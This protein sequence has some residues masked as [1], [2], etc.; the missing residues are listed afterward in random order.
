MSRPPAEP[1]D[2]LPELPGRPDALAPLPEDREE[3]GILPDLPARSAAPEALDLAFEPADDELVPLPARSTPIPSAWS[4]DPVLVPW[5][6][7]ATV[8]EPPER[9]PALL[10]PTRP[11]SARR[12]PPGPPRRAHVSLAGESF[13]VDLHPEP[14]AAEE[15]V[16]GRDALAG[17]FAVTSD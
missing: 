8:G 1:E 16:L 15:L 11:T 7:E 4:D 3:D 13:W 12:G 5:K 6:T 9:L 10:D 2:A 14:A 17:R